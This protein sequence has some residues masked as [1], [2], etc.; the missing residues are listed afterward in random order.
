[1]TTME[2]TV[3]ALIRI[4][5]LNYSTDGRAIF[6]NLNLNI[7]KGKVTA[8]M[9]PSGIGKTTLLRLIGGQ[10][11]PDSG[12]IWFEDKDIPTLHRKSLYQVRKRMGMLFQSGALFSELNVFEN[13]AFSLREHTK[14]PAD[15][16]KTIVMMKLEAVGLRGAGEL[17]PSQLSG[18]M[19]RRAALARAI[20]L[21]PDLVMFDEP[22]VGQDPITMGV[23]VEL[24]GQ[25][26]KALGI[27]CIVVSHDVPEVL[28]IADYAYII[29]DKQVIAEGTSAHLNQENEPRVRQFLDGLADGPV[30]FR[31]PAASYEQSVLELLKQKK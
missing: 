19:A 13:V 24:I 29:A 2:Q 3:D 10:L 16:I 14:L 27:T 28:S 1:M 26:N 21:D 30:P 5:N 23:L 25:I 31:Y 22:F 18:G 20:A 12:H 7:E 17:M 15:I 9:G 11:Q 8:I 6:S 4:E